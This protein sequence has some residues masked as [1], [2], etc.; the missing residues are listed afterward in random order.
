M[1][2]PTKWYNTQSEPLVEL[3]KSNFDFST[4]P[5]DTGNITQNI[6]LPSLGISETIF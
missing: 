4:T 5:P 1:Q 2:N 6:P 3:S